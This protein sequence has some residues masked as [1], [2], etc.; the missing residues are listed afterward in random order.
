MKG[1]WWIGWCWFLAWAVPLATGIIIIIISLICKCNKY[2]LIIGI[3]L[4]SSSFSRISIY[5]V[6]Y[7]LWPHEKGEDKLRINAMIVGYCES[8]LY[9]A[10]F[11][12]MR[13]EIIA[14]WI[15]LKEA[16]GWKMWF[17]RGDSLKKVPLKKKKEHSKRLART[18]VGNFL[19]IT[20][21]FIT[22]LI[23]A[24]ILGLDLDK[25]L[26]WKRFH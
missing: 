9:L 23:I 15:G 12:M 7:W 22:F 19:S 1:K 20:T 13:L 17:Q 16:L 24:W 4:F 5:S 25:L 26:F 11:F 21:S 18:L 8:V 3:V 14:F 6:L 10:S 2:I